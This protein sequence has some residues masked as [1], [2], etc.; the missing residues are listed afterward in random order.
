MAEVQV[1]ESS[2]RIAEK[3]PK[4]LDDLLK[5]V[6]EF[7]ATSDA[8]I[9]RKAYEFSEKAHQGQIRRSG[10]PYISH[11]LGVAGILADLKLDTSSIIT[12]LLHDTVEDTTVTLKDIETNFGLEVANLVDGVTK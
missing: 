2:S 7:Q 3:V 4:T 1:S 5:K 10:E 9:I 8:E 12:G 6:S 11:P